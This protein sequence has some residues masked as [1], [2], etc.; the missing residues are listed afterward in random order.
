MVRLRLPGIL[1]G[2]GQKNGRDS[3]RPAVEG[4]RSGV[5]RV[6]RVPAFH[7]SGERDGKATHR[8]EREARCRVSE[9]A[10]AGQT[11]CAGHGLG[12]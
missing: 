1:G 2:V 8:E 7:P 5:G 4:G 12:L 9:G 3:P 10:S 11:D 6:D